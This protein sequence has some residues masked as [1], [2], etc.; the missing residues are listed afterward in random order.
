MPSAVLRKGMNWN[1]PVGPSLLAYLAGVSDA[2]ASSIGAMID[3]IAWALDV[4]GFPPGTIKPSK[5]EVTAQFRRRLR[6]VHPDH[7]GDRMTASRS[8]GDLSEARRVLSH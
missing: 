3:P 2:R 6:D 4:L 5:R 1:G 7:G 8:I